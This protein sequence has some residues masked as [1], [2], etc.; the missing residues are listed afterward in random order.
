V[1]LQK[2]VASQPLNQ[3]NAGS[4]FRNPPGDHAARLIESCGLK[5]FAIGGAQVSTKHANFIVNLD[6]ASAR[7]IE[8]ILGHVHATVLARTG[9]DLVPEVRIVGEAA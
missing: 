1:L 9:V 5:G 6:G 3:P 2:R 8:S 4:V 7:D